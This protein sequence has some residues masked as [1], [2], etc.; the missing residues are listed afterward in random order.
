MVMMMTQRIIVF[1]LFLSPV[2]LKNRDI[3]YF[4][5][6][7][8]RRRGQ[9]QHSGVTYKLVMPPIIVTFDVN[10]FIATISQFGRIHDN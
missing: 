4:L 2:Q 3:N 6:R 9:V 1:N 10:F 7:F 5:S 8:D